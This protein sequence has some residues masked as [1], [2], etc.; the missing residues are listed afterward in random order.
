MHMKLAQKTGELQLLQKRVR[1]EAKIRVETETRRADSLQHQLD[2]L[3]ELQART[4]K[5]ARETEKEF[6]V[7]L[8]FRPS[9]LALKA[10]PAPHSPC[11][12]HPITHPTLFPSLLFASSITHTHTT[13]LPAP[14]AFSA[15]KRAA[16]RV[17]APQGAAERRPRRS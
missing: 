1:D 9:P 4:D 14:S 12:S 13:E 10:T 3:H 7:C 2:S 8:S 11:G 6:E 15:R 17:R 5:R 16:R